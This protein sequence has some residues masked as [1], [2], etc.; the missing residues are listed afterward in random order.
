[1]PFVEKSKIPNEIID[2]SKNEFIPVICSFD[3]EGNYVP[4]YFGLTLPDGE[5]KR[6]KINN[7]QWKKPNSIF[8]MIYCCDIILNDI[9]HIVYIY[10][11]DK[12]KKW[13]LRKS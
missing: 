12:M 10:Y 5:R 9:N 2:Y 13:S 1:M 3:T 8:G 11:H 6:I 4:V 7:V